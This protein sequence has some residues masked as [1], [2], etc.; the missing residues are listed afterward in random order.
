VQDLLPVK[1]ARGGI[2]AASCIQLN[3]RTARCHQN[4]AN[5]LPNRAPHFAE[6]S[7]VSGP[8]LRETKIILVNLFV[9][10]L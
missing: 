3:V 10:P 7:W 2:A 1:D 6:V 9:Q 5:P 8:Q 4:R